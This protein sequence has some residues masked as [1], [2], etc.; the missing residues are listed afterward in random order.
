MVKGNEKKPEKGKKGEKRKEYEE[1][2]EMNLSHLVDW[3]KSG[4]EC[5]S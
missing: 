3:A 4:S 2:W 5:G 1:N